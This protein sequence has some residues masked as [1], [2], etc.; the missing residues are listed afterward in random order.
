MSF[1]LFT[2]IILRE[3]YHIAKPRGPLGYQSLHKVISDIPGGNLI[4]VQIRTQEMHDNAERGKAAHWI[5]KMGGSSPN[6]AF[7]DRINSI[8]NALETIGDELVDADDLINL[9]NIEGLF[10]QISVFTPKKDRII[11]PVNSTPIDFAYHIHTDVGHECVGAKVN[12]KI[13]ALDQK[14]NHGDTVEVIRKKGGKP[15]LDWLQDD[16]VVS[17]SAKSKIRLYFRNR[18]RPHLI[19]V[20]NQIIQQRLKG[21][22]ELEISLED[23][24]SEFREVQTIKGDVESLSLAVAENRIDNIRL[25]RALGKAY[26]TKELR[27]QSFS[28]TKFQ[29]FL[30]HLSNSSLIAQPNEDQ[31][32]GAVAERKIS[33]N[34]FKKALQ[35]FLTVQPDEAFDITLDKTANEGKF[36][37]ESIST[38]YLFNL[39][40]CC[41]PIPGDEIV[42]YTTIGKGLSIHRNTC[43]NI[44][45]P[46]RRTRTTNDVAW[47][48]LP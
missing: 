40:K 46:S 42:G 44:L 38:K 47:V 2:G 41:C 18:E 25:N 17:S 37:F 5:Y 26:I 32:Y 35:A 23:L 7:I 10:E 27:N 12:G 8:R 36:I 22:K 16:F 34:D 13:V 24:L 19:E 11:L 15:N 20:G 48:T 3:G 6:Q 9:L 31:L 1:L 43:P 21:L 28:A 39:A 4:E 29:K 33:V 30:H 45:D 14:L